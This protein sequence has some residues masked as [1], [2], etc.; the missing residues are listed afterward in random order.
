MDDLS[1]A[2]AQSTIAA[3]VSSKIQIAVAVKAQDAEKQQGEEMVQ[4]IQSAAATA[5]GGVDTYA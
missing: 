3:D 5:R 1:I 4:M 2:S